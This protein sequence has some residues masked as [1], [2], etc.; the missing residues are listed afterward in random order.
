MTKTYTVKMSDEAAGI[1]CSFNGN[2]GI[3]RAIT[4]RQ[5]CIAR[6]ASE[7]KTSPK[8]EAL[9]AELIQLNIDGG[10]GATGEKIQSIK[11][12]DIMYT[13]RMMCLDK[14]L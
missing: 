4:N 14:S 13:A 1:I 12:E 11:Y 2:G 10:M 7:G 5:E 9:L 6:R 8:A 3:G